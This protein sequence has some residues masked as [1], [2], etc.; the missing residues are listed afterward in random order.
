MPKNLREALDTIQDMLSGKKYSEDLW[1]VLVALRGPDSRN[2]KV[3]SATTAVIRSMAF[4]KQP[5]SALSIFGSDSKE[6]ASRR[7]K[8]FKNREDHTHF[9][10]HVRD[11]FQSLE[12]ELYDV[13]RR[14]RGGSD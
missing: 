13:N 8:L 14:A 6:M 4:P 5:C 1:N 10:E 11:A 3:K 2:R 7:K 9:R 12:L